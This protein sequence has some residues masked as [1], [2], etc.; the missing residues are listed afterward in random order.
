MIFADFFAEFFAYIIFGVL[1]LHCINV[2]YYLGAKARVSANVGLSAGLQARS[3]T[4]GTLLQIIH[5]PPD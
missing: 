1:Y 4:Q 3:G 2:I 5:F